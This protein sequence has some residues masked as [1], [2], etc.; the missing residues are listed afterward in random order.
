MYNPSMCMAVYQLVTESQLGSTGV[1]VDFRI[2]SSLEPNMI[3]DSAS[4]T[5]YVHLWAVRILSRL[6]AQNPNVKP[7]LKMSV[8][9]M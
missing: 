8:V 2:R 9:F 3:D 6:W 1:L 5:G 7:G 4:S